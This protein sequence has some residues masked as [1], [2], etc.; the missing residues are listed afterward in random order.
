[1][2]KKGMARPDWTHPRPRNEVPPVPLIQGKAKSGKI[3]VQPIIEGTGGPMLKVF[4]QKPQEHEG[5]PNP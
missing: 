5:D 2:P 4:H 3:Q 1:M